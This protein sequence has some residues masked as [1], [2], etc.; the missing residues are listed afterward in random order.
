MYKNL[1]EHTDEHHRGV[2]VAFDEK[3]KNHASN[4]S[5]FLVVGKQ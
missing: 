4:K 2:K 5:F 1:Y 3:K